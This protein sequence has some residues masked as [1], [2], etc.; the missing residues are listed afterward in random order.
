MFNAKEREDKIIDSANR[1]FFIN[2]PAWNRTK[3][4]FGRPYK[5]RCQEPLAQERLLSATNHFIILSSIDL[6]SL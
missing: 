3:S 2:T 6:S 1:K 5:S 4:P